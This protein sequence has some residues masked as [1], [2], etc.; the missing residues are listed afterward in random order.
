[1]TQ[2]TTA[3]ATVQAGLYSRLHG[4][5]TLT[6]MLAGQGIFDEVPENAPFPYVTIANNLEIR[7]DT[8]NRRGRD[9][10]IT[11]DIWSQ[12]HGFNEALTILA[13]CIALLDRQPLTLATGSMS[14]INFTGTPQ[15]LRDPDDQ[16]TRHVVARFDSCV[17][18]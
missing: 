2:L 12:G 1:M 5:S 14:Y 11:L 15:M 13:R 4:D 18:E 6:A 8:F 3:L 16:L 9:V 10:T 7:N 17:E